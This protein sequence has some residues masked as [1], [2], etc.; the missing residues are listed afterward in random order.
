[1]ATLNGLNFTSYGNGTCAVNGITDF[2]DWKSELTGDIILPMK[3]STGDI[4]TTLDNTSFGYSSI[5]SIILPS[6][7]VQI[8]SSSFYNCADLSRVVLSDSLKQ[9]NERTF[10]GCTS[11][12]SI[13][14]PSGVTSIRSNLE[15]G[16][17]TPIF[18]N[19]S[20][21]LKIYCGATSKPDDWGI[22]WNY[23]SKTGQLSV[24]WG[25]TRAQYDS[26]YA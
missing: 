12:E 20:A 18:Y 14:I 26:Q 11:L 22:H 4:V 7:L 25:V 17:S 23:Y 1:M 6:T 3:S 9:I 24:T 10:Y 2:G 8:S 21:S 5:T 15:D 16:Y 13:Y 19:C